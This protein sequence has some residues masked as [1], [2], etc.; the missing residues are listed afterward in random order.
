[1]FLFCPPA[2]R[3]V[4]VFMPCFSVASETCLHLNHGSFRS[5]FP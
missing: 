3:S 5:V 4:L 1:M 2:R